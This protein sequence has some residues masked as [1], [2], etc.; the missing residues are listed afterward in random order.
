[1]ATESF[2]KGYKWLHWLMAAMVIMMIFAGQRFSS[3]MPVEEHMMGLTGH[4]TIGTLLVIL[5]SIRIYKRFVAKHPIPDPELPNWQK[6]AARLVQFGLYA[7]LVMVPLSGYLTATFHELP[8]R[9]F[10]QI[11]ISAL[12]EHNETIFLY[13]RG[14]HETTIQLLV[15]FL[16]MHIGAALY[17]HFIVRDG[18]LASMGWS[19][20][21]SAHENDKPTMLE[22]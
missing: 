3:N 4:T 2:S 14:V 6:Q 19:T 18:I 16:F 13:M 12:A 15:L 8:V 9:A 11:D 21:T 17:H 10:G 5:L 22:H 20:K 1:M 7:L